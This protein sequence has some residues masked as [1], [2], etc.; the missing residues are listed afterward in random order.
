MS[1]YLF[2]D[3]NPTLKLN[4]ENEAKYIKKLPMP[5]HLPKESR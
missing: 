3:K 5:S 1:D 2:L 4:D